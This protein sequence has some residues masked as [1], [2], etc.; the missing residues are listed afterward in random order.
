MWRRWAGGVWWGSV[1]GKWAQGQGTVGGPEAEEGV[2]L[3]S[4]PGQ[5][6][7]FPEFNS[8]LSWLFQWRNWGRLEAPL[9]CSPTWS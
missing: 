6:A 7:S 5:A 9:T 4:G 1:E 2:G 3:G 8:N